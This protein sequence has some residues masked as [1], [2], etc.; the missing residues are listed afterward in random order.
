ML[1]CLCACV[2]FCDVWCVV[3]CAR[4]LR[5]CC[6]LDVL[7]VVAL[8]AGVATGTASTNLPGRVSL[9]LRMHGMDSLNGWTHGRMVHGM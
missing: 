1:V 8:V 4:V 2:H 3:C 9:V 7:L 5:V 6:G